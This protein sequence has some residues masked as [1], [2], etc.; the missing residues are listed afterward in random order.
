MV[1]ISAPSALHW[2]SISRAWRS[3]GAAAP[4]ARRPCAM[5][6]R[7]SQCPLLWPAHGNHHPPNRPHRYKLNLWDVG[8]QRSLRPFWRNYFERTDG[9]VWVVDA[10][11]TGRLADCAA[12]L[13]ALLAEERLQG[14]PLLVLANKQDVAGALQLHQVEEVCGVLCLLRPGVSLMGCHSLALSLCPATAT[15]ATSSTGSDRDG[16]RV[17]LCP[18]LPAAPPLPTTGAAAVMHCQAPGSCHWL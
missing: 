3:R 17:Q 16:P 9:L 4:C 18:P 5:T 12:E 11:D 6:L 2:A 13:T 1:R 14:A 15:C 10:C 7:C 8:G